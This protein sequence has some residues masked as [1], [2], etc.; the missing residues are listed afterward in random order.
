MMNRSQL[1][2]AVLAVTLLVWRG[3]SALA[4][5]PTASP[6]KSDV[7]LQTPAGVLQVHFTPPLAG[8]ATVTCAPASSTPEPGNPR[9]TVILA[10]LQLTIKNAALTPGGR[11]TISLP[12]KSP[13]NAAVAI[14]GFL[15]NRI[16]IGELAQQT[17]DHITGEMTLPRTLSALQIDAK[18]ARLTLAC[19]TLA[20]EA[21][22]TPN[23][24]VYKYNVRRNRWDAYH[25]TFDGKRAA[26]L[27]SGPTLPS[28]LDKSAPERLTVLAAALSRL[29][30]PFSI[31]TVEYPA[32]CTIAGAGDAL[33]Q[34]LTDKRAADTKIDLVARGVGG[35]AARWALEQHAGGTTGVTRLI[36]VGA[37]HLGYSTSILTSLALSHRALWHAA[38]DDLARDSHCLHT[39]NNGKPV[40]C[41]YAAIVGTAAPGKTHALSGLA[42]LAS[43]PNDGAVEA[44][45]AGYALT[46]Q[47]QSYKSANFALDDDAL[48][49]DASVAKTIQDW[50]TPPVVIPPPTAGAEKHNP[51]DDAVMVYIPA[52]VFQM[53]ASDDDIADLLRTHR[54]WDRAWFKNEQPQHEVML[55]G[56]WMYKYEV[57][58][59]Q[60]RA[61][62][63]ATRREMPPAPEWGWQDDHPI[64]NVSWYDA[65][66]Y[67]SW[68][69]AQLPT[70]A[71]W[72]KAARGSDARRFPWGS[73]WDATKCNNWEDK[74]PKGGGYH[75]AMT[76]PVGSYPQGASPYGGQDMAG[77]AWEWCADW[78][79]EDTYK[80][81]PHDNPTG[82]ATGAARVIRGGGWGYGNDGSYR[83]TT[84]E[85]IGFPTH[86]WN[87][88]GF[89]CV[90][91]QKR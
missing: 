61:F 26:V 75:S 57:T 73:E 88:G 83:C 50:L 39:L 24:A 11:V 45:S 14:V 79:G 37:P 90:T 80:S 48:A 1:I 30:P 10:P 65:A 74:D 43:T 44:S 63:K 21:N 89:R 35:L 64:V 53:G 3:A 52:G 5:P 62:C 86:Y 54:T 2:H 38:F 34:L 42:T 60:Y 67:A 51:R 7:T 23:L 17:A 19:W 18:T 22:A 85:Q 87:M 25:D 32:G 59:Q 55:D 72:E 70:E 46:Q 27:L 69:G 28:I 84:R 77:N 66:A 13:V 29:D 16:W 78:W 4:A 8:T 71:Q 56:Y 47:A 76:A 31:Y 36:T 33:A 82:P 9:L 20:R 41:D 68:A 49:R 6:V 91:A 81:S 58:V 40:A 15:D 12:A